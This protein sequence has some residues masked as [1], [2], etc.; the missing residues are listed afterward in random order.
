LSSIGTT[1]IADVYG[2]HCREVR[3]RRIEDFDRS[4][5][6]IAAA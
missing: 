1:S 5:N 3:Q 4:R 2:R 6:R